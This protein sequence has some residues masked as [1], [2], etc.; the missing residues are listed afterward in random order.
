MARVRDLI[1]AIIALLLIGWLLLLIIPLLAFTQQRV[2]FLQERT[3]WRGRP[4]RMIKFSTL[5]DV[6]PGE[7][8]DAPQRYRLTPVGKILRRLS[9]DELPQ[10]WNVLRG[11]MAM[12][13]PRPLIH[14]YWPLY[15]ELQKRRFEVRPGI[16]G[17]AQVNGRN[18]LSFTQRFELDVW[19]VDHRTPW[20]DFKIMCMTLGQVFRAKG[21]Y[22]DSANT[23][24]RF[25]GHN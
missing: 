14:D 6:S 11:D 4:F 23:M 3:G 10:L 15:S 8:E 22:A 9:V 17:W 21:V 2:F 1:L 5:R 24:E 12:V 13:G 7:A 18:A 20:L 25:D 19:Y 16:T